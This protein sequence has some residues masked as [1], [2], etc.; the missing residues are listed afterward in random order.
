MQPAGLLTVHVNADPRAF[1]IHHIPKIYMADLHRNFHGSVPVYNHL[2]VPVDGRH[3]S[4]KPSCRYRIA[5]LSHIM[6]T[7]Q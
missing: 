7:I 1:L 4:K 3:L 5:Y 2:L 6:Q